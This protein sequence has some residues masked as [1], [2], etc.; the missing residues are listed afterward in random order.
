MISGRLSPAEEP[1][2]KIGSAI[3]AGWLHQITD[4]PIRAESDSPKSKVPSAPVVVEREALLT[5]DGDKEPLKSS[6]SMGV[7]ETRAPAIGP[8]EDDTIRET[9]REGIR[10]AVAGEEDK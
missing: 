6:N 4:I 8:P 3:K 5:S 2:T 10:E 1:E 7:Q 9:A